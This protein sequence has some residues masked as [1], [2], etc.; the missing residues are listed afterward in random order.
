MLTD[1][2]SLLIPAY[3]GKYAVGLFN[4]INME[5]VRGVIEAGIEEKSPLIVGTA[6]RFLDFVPLEYL[7]DSIIGASKRADIPIC[8]HFDHGK[9][10]ENCVRAMDLGFTSIMFD[11]SRLPY[12]EN[13]KQMKYITDLAHARGITVEGELGA[14]MDNE[15]SIEGEPD[16]LKGNP[17]DYYT[18][19]QIARDFVL[20]TGVDA[21]AVSVGNAHGAYKFPP[22]LDFERIKQIR[23]AVDVPLVLHGGSG[24]TDEDFRKAIS[25]GIAKVNIFTEINNACAGAV[26]PTKG[27]ASSVPKM[28][29]AVKKATVEKIRMFGSDNRA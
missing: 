3:R 24:L 29:E 20:R 28:V 12:E 23:D 7:A 16:E 15:G 11:A 9:T 2:N 4:V 10:V 22:K 13:V 8:L 14:V 5:M 18:D 19:P 26:D 6:E 25:L 27:I 21:L 1:L 17:S